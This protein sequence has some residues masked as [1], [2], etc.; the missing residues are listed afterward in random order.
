[1]SMILKYSGLIVP[2]TTE[3][4]TIE[5]IDRWGYYWHYRIGSSTIMMLD[6]SM[7]RYTPSPLPITNT[8][9]GCPL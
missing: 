6:L 7:Y 4:T 9:D 3:K 5:T 1:M 2:Y 8:M